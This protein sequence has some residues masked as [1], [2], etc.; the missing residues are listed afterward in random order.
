[1]RPARHR[2]KA[3]T[4]HAL[5]L[6]FVGMIS[7]EKPASFSGSCFAAE[8]TVR[9]RFLPSTRAI[10]ALL[11]AGMLALG[12]ALFLRY[13]VIENST[14]GLACEAGREDFVCLARITAIR[15]LGAHAFGIVA[16]GAA[17]LNLFRPALLLLAIAL[18]GTAFGLVLYNTT[19][20]GLA[21][22][23]LVM[24]FARPAREPAQSQAR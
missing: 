13:R 16:L 7:S 2:V 19:L 18:L 5:F 21:A 4:N 3:E 1:M 22:G 12:C 23:L 11:A 20:A 8:R 15:L 17:L 14:V 24:S 9:P 6:F 10:C